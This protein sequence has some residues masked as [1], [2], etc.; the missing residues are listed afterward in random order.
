MCVYV[1]VYMR[2]CVCVCICVY[3]GVCVYVFVYMCVMKIS[4]CNN[5]RLPKP[6][7]SSLQTVYLNKTAVLR[8][9]KI[10]VTSGTNFFSISYIDSSDRS[11]SFDQISQ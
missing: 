5:A 3:A 11:P 8:K 6:F 2:A 7:S 10:F 4:C 1:F 9:K